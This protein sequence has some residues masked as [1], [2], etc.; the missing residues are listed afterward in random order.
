M[1]YYDS[2]GIYVS[3]ATTLVGKIAN[4]DKVIEALEIMS[5]DAAAT[6]NYAEYSLDNGQ[7]RIKTVYRSLVQ[8]GLAIR[9]F[10]AIRQRYINRLN[11]R[12]VRLVDGKN[13]SYRNYFR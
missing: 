8:I 3:S 12:N 1:V 10:E 6:G 7:S 4:I 13:F 5:I 9:E 11:G 2:A